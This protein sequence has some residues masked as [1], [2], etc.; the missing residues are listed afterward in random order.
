MR[1][2]GTLTQESRKCAISGL[3]RGS[4]GSPG[5][6]W[7]FGCHPRG[8]SQGEPFA[9]REATAPSNIKEIKKVQGGEQ[10][11]RNGALALPKDVAVEPLRPKGLLN[12]ILPILLPST[13]RGSNGPPGGHADLGRGL[14]GLQKNS[15]ERV[16]AVE[17]LAT[18]FRPDIV[19]QEAPED[20][21]GLADVREATR[22]V[23]VQT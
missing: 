9:G 23:A 4:P 1:D 13:T 20:V 19:K 16:K 6:K 11:P 15:F 17:V 14:P 10:A 12:T 7:P 22:V 5:T 8:E 3:S 2:F 21:E 18:P